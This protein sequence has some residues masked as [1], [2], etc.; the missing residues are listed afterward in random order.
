MSRDILFIGHSLVGKVMP[1][2]LSSL[3]PPGTQSPQVDRQVINGA[4][5][6]WNWANGASA[7]GVNARAVLPS[8]RYG[9][10]VVT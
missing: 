4:P 7:E 2:M 8:G 9:V 6:A 10:V 5:L 1:N 3:I